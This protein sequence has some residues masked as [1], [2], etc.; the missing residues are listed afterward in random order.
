VAGITDIARI[1]GF[2]VGTVS[3]ALSGNKHVDDKTRSIILK[4][5]EE[6]NY[7]PNYFAQNL[8]AKKSDTIAY[9]I[10]DIENMIYPPLASVIEKEARKLGYSLLLC[11]TFN[12]LELSGK[13]ISQFKSRNVDGFLISTAFDATLNNENI[14]S[15]KNEGY[16][17]V[18][19]LRHSPD[20]RDSILVDNFLGAEMAVNYLVSR[21]LKKIAF[22]AGDSN[23]TLYKERFD[24]YLSGLEKNSIAFDER[25]IWQGIRGTDRIAFSE[26]KRKLS[27]GCLPD[28]IFGS[29]D[30]LAID[31]MKAVFDVGYHVPND[32]SVIGFD[33][34]PI[35]EM[36]NPGLT[37]I[38]QPFAKMGREAVTRL[39]KQ[40]ED[41][42][43][44]GQPNE[45]FNPSVVIRHSVR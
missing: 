34:L 18:C 23:L 17:T 14:L 39:I 38:E 5:A 24:G 30:P 1:S 21:G 6:N 15:L 45:I 3:R 8:K 9:L 40:I 19:L 42:S 26:V 29:S 33:N 12:D 2:S 10:P 28:A 32:I 31:A 4:C 25:L 11:N 36:L 41:K 35:S 13:Y 16:P 27:E 7:S 22:I 43:T 20:G 37:T 44:I